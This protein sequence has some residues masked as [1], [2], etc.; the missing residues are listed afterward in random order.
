MP[1]TVVASLDD[2][3]DI[4]SQRILMSLLFKS[5]ML[6]FYFHYSYKNFTTVLAATQQK[7]QAGQ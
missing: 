4:L 2:A 7:S 5:M 6:Y 3:D 1:G